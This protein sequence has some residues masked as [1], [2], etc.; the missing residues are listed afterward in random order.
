[1]FNLI[2]QENTPISQYLRLAMDSRMTESGLTIE[3]IAEY[4][5]RDPS[6]IRA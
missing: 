3:E 4:I 1:M 2:M 5:G 6:S